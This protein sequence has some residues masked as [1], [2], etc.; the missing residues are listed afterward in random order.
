MQIYYKSYKIEDEFI[1]KFNS[2]IYWI[3]AYSDVGNWIPVGNSCKS[4]KEA[5]ACIREYLR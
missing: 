1:E 4:I 5:K 2:T 3:Y